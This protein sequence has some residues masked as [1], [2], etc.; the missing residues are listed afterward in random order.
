MVA[1]SSPVALVALLVVLGGA[2]GAVWVQ[3]VEP[4]PAPAVPEKAPARPK[5]HPAPESPRAAFGHMCGTCHTLR[6][7]RATGV[8]GP[9]L[10]ELKPSAAHVQRKIRTGSSRGI[11]PS[12]LLSGREA[13][14][15]AEY[16]AR[17]AG[18]AS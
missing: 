12:N 9:N 7:A 3:Q 18:R 13:L 6:A 8:L 16:V 1:R 10:D 5:P 14:D 17:V 15:V 4:P 11:M 2:F